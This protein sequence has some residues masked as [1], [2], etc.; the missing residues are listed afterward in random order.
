MYKLINRKRLRLARKQ[1][2][3]RRR[4][5]D[6][7]KPRLCV[8]RSSKHIQAQLIDDLTGNVIASVSSV[9][10]ELK[11]SS[12]DSLKGVAVA[13]LIGTEIANRVL[14]KGVTTVVFDRNGFSYHGRIAALAD[15]ARVAGLKF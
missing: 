4:K 5:L 13:K 14:A 1:R 3:W 7:S 6:S 15:A 12:L 8:F 9:Q 10:K 11:S 2:F